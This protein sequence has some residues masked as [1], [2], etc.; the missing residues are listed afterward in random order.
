MCK[1]HAGRYPPRSLPPCSAS[2]VLMNTSTLPQAARRALLAEVADGPALGGGHGGRTF[3][4]TFDA[5][6]PDAAAR[7]EV[8]KPVLSSSSSSSSSSSTTTTKT[9]TT[10]STTA[11]AAAATTTATTEAPSPEPPVVIGEHASFYAAVEAPDAPPTQ[12]PA[13]SS[14]SSSS[15]SSDPLQTVKDKVVSMWAG[16]I[17]DDDGQVERIACWDI[18]LADQ[19]LASIVGNGDASRGTAVLQ[20]MK[21]ER[22]LDQI[23]QDGRISE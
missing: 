16:I 2:S 11:A 14:S 1:A 22:A 8:K 5:L 7:A 3:A 10:T 19:E 15:S 13:L 23:K 21:D 4:K 9:T 17:K 18:I 12:K 6:P 20:S